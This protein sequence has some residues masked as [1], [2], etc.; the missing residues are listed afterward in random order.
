MAGVAALLLFDS[1]IL[2]GSMAP[3]VRAVRL[4]GTV[5]LGEWN[6]TSKEGELQLVSSDGV[7]SVP[8]DDLD[9]VT[10]NVVEKHSKGQVLFHLADGGRLRGT[11][12][13]GEADA[14][15][16]RTALGDSARLAWDKLAGIQW[17]S[18]ESFYRADQRFREALSD[19]VPSQDVLI[20]RDD[21]FT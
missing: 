8:T 17:A 16:G 13:G 9:S 3:S 18:A 19:R 20:S 6:G 15:L 4:D 10:F 7:V 11:I 1:G 21:R 12:V 2:A 5:A 14:V